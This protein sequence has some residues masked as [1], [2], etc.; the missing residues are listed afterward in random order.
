MPRNPSSAGSRDGL[1]LFL[2]VPALASVGASEPE[3]L[4]WVIEESLDSAKVFVN[5]QRHVILKGMNEIETV[6][7]EAVSSVDGG[8][9]V[10][11]PDRTPRPWI[12]GLLIAPSA[13]VANGVIQGG[14]LAYLLSVHG[15]GSGAQSHLIFLLALPTSLYFLWS[16]ITDFFVR[17]RTWLG[18]GGVLAAFLMLLGFHQKNLSGHLAFT[19]L[20][21][22]ACCVQLV[23]SSC[24]GMMGSIRSDITKRQSS[25]YYQAGSMGFGALSA[26]GLVWLSSRTSQNTLGIVAAGMIGIPAL[27]AFAAP[28]QPEISTGALG[29]TMHRVWIEFKLT[30]WRK[31]AL[32]YIATLLFP[33]GSGAAVGLLSGV[34][35]QYGVGGDG[36]AWIN[37][38][39]GGLMT[40]LGAA[41]VILIKVRARAAVLYLTLTA[42]N[43]LP[44]CVLWLG[45][46]TPATY[47]LGVL[48]YL[49]TVGCCYSL[50]TA[51]VLEFMGESGKSGSGRY[52]LVNS[53]GNVPVLYMV[54]LDGW[55]GDKWG[56]RGVAGT[57]C[58][59]GAIGAVVLLA[60][61]LTNKPDRALTL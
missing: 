29:E 34:A 30:F 60:Y 47:Y 53:L 26:W 18:L 17:R 28:K 24:G 56:G 14:V 4:L 1:G 45:P 40:A 61:F 13:V 55:G 48:L 16:P 7:T 43:C 23:V 50:F 25:S 6:G 15:V 5:M 8:K 54:I 57:E 42:I 22:S 49:F 9:V 27:F 58:V 12:F 33:M 38:L 20:L 59:V 44:L 10:T 19:L 51:V 36:V 3:I 41:V 52:S 37:G 46:L 31:E 32:P 39:V 11:D 2:C 21:L 35:R